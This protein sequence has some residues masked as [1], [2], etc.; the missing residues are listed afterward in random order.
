[1]NVANQFDAANRTRTK[2][3]QS[4]VNVFKPRQSINATST[5]DDR[6]FGVK[7]VICSE[8]HELFRCEKFKALSPDQRLERVREHRVCFCCL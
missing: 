3:K 1:M 8:S 5:V 2:V 7:C 6:R 4:K